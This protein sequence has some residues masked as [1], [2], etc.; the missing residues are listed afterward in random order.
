VSAFFYFGA[1]VD[2]GVPFNRHV[3]Q[4]TGGWIGPLSMILAQNSTTDALD[5]YVVRYA[6]TPT[7][8]Y[9]HMH[10]NC[11]LF[12]PEDFERSMGTIAVNETI[13]RQTHA[14]HGEDPY[15]PYLK[16]CDNGDVKP[17]LPLFDFIFVNDTD[18]SEKLEIKLDYKILTFPKKDKPMYKLFPMFQ[19]KMNKRQGSTFHIS[20]SYCYGDDPKRGWTFDLNWDSKVANDYTTVV[21]GCVE[22]L[23]CLPSAA[24]I[25]VGGPAT[26]MIHVD[27]RTGTFGSEVFLTIVVYALSMALLIS[28]TY[29]CKNSQRAAQEHRRQRPAESNPRPRVPPGPY[30]DLG[31]G[32]LNHPLLEHED[33]ASETKENDADEATETANVQFV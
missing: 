9:L 24:E 28:I 3:D 8:P 7:T 32:A 6:Q 16:T 10:P 18:G 26:D 19:E 23:P 13:Q 14:S 12:D 25:S 17:I 15:E 21:H 4:N 1:R 27:P 31:D 29:N 33:A 22:G 2:A 20:G 11:T 5:Q 30:G